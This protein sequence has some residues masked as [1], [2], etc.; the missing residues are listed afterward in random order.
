MTLEAWIRNRARLGDDKAECLGLWFDPEASTDFVSQQRRIIDYV[1]LRQ[2][3][4]R[5]ALVET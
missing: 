3:E 5:E 4:V 2:R 1:V